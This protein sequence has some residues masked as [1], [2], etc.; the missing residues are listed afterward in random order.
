MNKWF[1]IG[2]ATGFYFCVNNKTSSPSPGTGNAPCFFAGDIDSNF[3]N[4]ASRFAFI[5]SSNRTSDLNYFTWQNTLLYLNAG[6][7]IGKLYEVDGG[8]NSTHYKVGHS[9]SRGTTARN[10]VPPGVRAFYSVELFTVLQP[11]SL[12][13]NSVPYGESQT[14][15]YA[16]GRIPGLIVSHASGYL[17]Q[18]WPVIEQI[19]GQ[20]HLLLPGYYHGRLW[21]NMEA[22]YD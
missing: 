19:N 8:D 18:A 14:L 20:S 1:I 13:P 22:W 5:M 11:D 6:E 9:F 4:D 3:P 7:T 21:V 10:G 17:D 16:R 12:D 2:T 15:P